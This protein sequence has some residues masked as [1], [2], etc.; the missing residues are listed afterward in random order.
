MIHDRWSEM[1]TRSRE[2]LPREGTS[3]RESSG[4]LTAL[5]VETILAVFTVAISPLN[6]R[7]SRRVRIATGVSEVDRHNEIRNSGRVTRDQNS[8]TLQAIRQSDSGVVKTLDF[9]GPEGRNL[10]GARRAQVL[11]MIREQPS[12]GTR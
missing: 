9:L 5:G 6:K 12:T 8:L 2:F 1:A 11:T 10:S 7:G 4:R 3:D